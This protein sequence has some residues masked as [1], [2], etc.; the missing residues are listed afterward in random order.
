[1]NIGE[2]THLE[3]DYRFFD[4]DEWDMLEV[5][6]GTR[7]FAETEHHALTLRL[8]GDWGEVRFGRTWS[9]GW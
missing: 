5:Y 8:H 4:L 7:D 6:T 1:M 3:V 9:N 2:S